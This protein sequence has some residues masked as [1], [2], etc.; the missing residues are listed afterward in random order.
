VEEEMGE[1]QA[2]FRKERGITD[3]CNQ[4]SIWK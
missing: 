4:R 2:G 1:E 3:I